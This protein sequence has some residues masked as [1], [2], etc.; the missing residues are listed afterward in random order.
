MIHFEQS[1]GDT[2][3]NM[4]SSEELAIFQDSLHNQF[5]S[6][7]EYNMLKN[8]VCSLVNT[9]DQLEIMT[10]KLYSFIQ[11]SSGDEERQKDDME[12]AHGVLSQ[13][14]HGALSQDVNNIALGDVNGE[15]VQEEKKRSRASIGEIRR[16]QRL[17]IRRKDEEKKSLQ[18][19]QQN[20]QQQ[21][22]K[23]II[24]PKSERL[25]IAR[26]R[27]IAKGN[28]GPHLLNKFDDEDFNLESL[29]ESTPTMM[30]KRNG[31]K[32]S[33]KEESFGKFFGSL[34][35]A[36]FAV[37]LTVKGLALLLEYIRPD[38]LKYHELT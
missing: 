25:R 11:G 1:D 30:K 7:D 26:E 34:I 8:Q 37:F 13:D 6:L 24:I 29:L 23:R 36:L 9:V 19:Q 28:T 16:V 27:A 20:Q 15:N 17:M 33:N 14:V 35:M 18:Q 2:S 21:R 31:N 4:I 5:V 12:D 38:N 3:R 10:Q 22:K 32:H